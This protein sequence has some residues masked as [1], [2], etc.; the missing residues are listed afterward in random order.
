M[1]NV[2]FMDGHVKSMKPFDLLA[3]V[4][5]KV[6]APPDS[7]VAQFIKEV[8]ASRQ[9]IRADTGEAVYRV[10]ADA[11]TPETLP[12][13]TA[14][15]TAASIAGIKQAAG[16]WHDLLD[17]EGLKAYIR[18]RRKIKDRPSIQL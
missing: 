3:G 9:P 6:Q 13:P 12:L 7:E 5:Y 17:A 8:A 16:S 2:G 18:E 1:M 11:E 14:E 4:K 15:E 10:E